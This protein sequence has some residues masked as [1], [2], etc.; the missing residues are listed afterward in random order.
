MELTTAPSQWQRGE[1]TI[2]TS[3]ALLQPDVINE[4]FGSDYMYWTRTM[5][6]EG[7][8]KMLSHSFCF[9]V[10]RNISQPSVNTERKKLD[11][12]GFAR[13]VT[14]E[15][16]MAY[17]TDVFILPDYRGQGLGKWLI[18]CINE[19]VNQWPDLRSTMLFAGGKQA[20]KFYEKM[21]GARIFVP[22]PGKTEI[23]QKFGPGDVFTNSQ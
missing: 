3:H 4:A 6:E 5:T 2:S 17:L 18:G 16:T 15:T 12:I 8:K 23:M 22:E 14:D 7:M 21:L 10:Y 11:Q 20:E 13:L 9:G 1:F 19:T